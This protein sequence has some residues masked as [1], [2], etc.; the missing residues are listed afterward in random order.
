MRVEE[1]GRQERGDG[2]A[3]TGRTVKWDLDGG[4]DQADNRTKGIRAIHPERMG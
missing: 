2:R 4:R 3:G 1:T